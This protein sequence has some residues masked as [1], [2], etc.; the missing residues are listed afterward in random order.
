MDSPSGVAAEHQAI[1]ALHRVRSGYLQ[2]RTARI[3]AARGHLRESGI[4]IPAG[5]RKVIPFVRSALEEGAVP[6]LLTDV[7]ADLLE[8]ID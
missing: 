5:A 2:T 6:A 8:D 3:N 4:N 7:L 1:A